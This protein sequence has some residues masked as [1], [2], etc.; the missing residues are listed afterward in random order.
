[1]QQNVLI[2][3]LYLPDDVQNMVLSWQTF[4]KYILKN[5]YKTN[6]NKKN[7]AFQSFYGPKHCII[8]VNKNKKHGN[9]LQIRSKT[10]YYHDKKDFKK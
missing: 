7:M 10:W 1:M 4:Y 3:V 6:N 8:V 5:M 9:T 2:T